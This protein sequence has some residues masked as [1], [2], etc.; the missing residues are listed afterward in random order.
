MTPFRLDMTSSFLAQSAAKAEW[1]KCVIRQWH[2]MRWKRVCSGRVFSS[3]APGQSWFIIPEW[4]GVDP[5]LL[6]CDFLHY[7]WVGHINH[8][9]DASVQCAA[10]LVSSAWFWLAC[11]LAYAAENASKGLFFL[12][13]PSDKIFHDDS[14]PAML[15]HCDY[16]SV[17]V[18][19]EFKWQMIFRM[20]PST[21]KR[22]L[23]LH[24]FAYMIGKWAIIC[25]VKPRTFILK[26][27]RSLSS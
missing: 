4:I 5:S 14:T 22:Q 18:S 13:T 15:L 16:D 9:V 24:W 17:S 10:C 2:L 25:N 27:V 6:L 19:S 8:G 7:V 26:N 1:V 12:K 21:W 23:P 20:S 11:R 3:S